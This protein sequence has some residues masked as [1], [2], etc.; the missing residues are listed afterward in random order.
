MK[1]LVLIVVAL[2]ALV[3][4]EVVV[5][6]EVEVEV[7]V[8]VGVFDGEVFTQPVGVQ[9]Q[10]MYALMCVLRPSCRIGRC[11]YLQVHLNTHFRFEI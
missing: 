5:V 11:M 6:L 8:E 7:E 10:H 9:Q 2:L 4:E 3:K 1:V